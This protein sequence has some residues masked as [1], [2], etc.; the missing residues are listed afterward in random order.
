MGNTLQKIERRIT[1]FTALIVF[2]VSFFSTLTVL[3]YKTY[4]NQS[5]TFQE[6]TLAFST[7][8]SVSIVKSANITTE[9]IIIIENL[10]NEPDKVDL[11]IPTTYDRYIEEA[12][13]KYNINKNLIRSVIL[14]E[15]NFD[16][17]AVSRAG[18]QGLMQL[19]PATAIGLG[20]ID[21]FDAKQN[22]EGGTRYLSYM[23]DRY[24]GDLILALAAYNA[25]PG[26]VDK[27]SGVP[28]FKETT[29]YVEKVMT[30]YGQ[31]NNTLYARHH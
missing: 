7:L 18:A 13:K 22:I 4:A 29:N 6:N 14:H 17:K 20:V 26:N 27:F 2:V 21:S 25:G 3:S 9:T 30:T 28:P 24:H 16:S 19:M 8:N 5:T 1:Y 15:S 31:L 23:L 10:K 11:N 12:A